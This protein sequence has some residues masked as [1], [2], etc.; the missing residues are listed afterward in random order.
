LGSA[1]A[2][3]APQRITVYTFHDQ[4]G[5]IA[6]FLDVVNRCDVEKVSRSEHRRFARESGEV[7]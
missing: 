6:R 1:L 4:R 5:P 7:T 3:C 2:R